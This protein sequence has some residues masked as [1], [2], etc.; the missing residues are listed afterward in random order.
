MLKLLVRTVGMAISGLFMA[1]AVSPSAAA[2]DASEQSHNTMVADLAARA[3]PEDCQF[4][5]LSGPCCG[6][7]LPCEISCFDGNGTALIAFDTKPSSER[8]TAVVVEESAYLACRRSEPARFTP[9]ARGA[10]GTMT[11]RA[12]SRIRL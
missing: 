5:A 2:H 6:A 11:F 3:D 9:V 7:P 4:L 10:P 1:L 8:S 12:T